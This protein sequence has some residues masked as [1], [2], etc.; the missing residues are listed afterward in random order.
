M[1]DDVAKIPLAISISRKTK[2][3][4]IENIVFAIAV[5]LTLLVLCSIG[6]LPLFAAVLGDVGGLIL[7]ILNA[8]RSGR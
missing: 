1:D 8:I 7:S 3:V 2:R 4:V 6:I 5:K